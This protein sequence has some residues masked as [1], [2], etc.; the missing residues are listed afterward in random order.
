MLIFCISALRAIVEM[1]GLCLIGQALLY[2]LAG[3]SCDKNPIY[4]LFSLITRRPQ[5]LVGLLLPAKTSS[6]II[7]T[8]SFLLLFSLWIGLAWLRKLL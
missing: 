1:L 8:S 5:Q 2:V 6:W 7:G 3:K 4:Q